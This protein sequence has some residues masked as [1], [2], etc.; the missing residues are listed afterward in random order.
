MFDIEKLTFYADDGFGLVQN[1]DRQI[2]D[3]LMEKK[4]EK[5]ISWL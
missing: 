4:F 1:R 5:M 2:L 3:N